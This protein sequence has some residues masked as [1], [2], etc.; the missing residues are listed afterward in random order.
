MLPS[1]LDAVRRARS[2]FILATTSFLSVC[3]TARPLLPTHELHRAPYYHE[4][5]SATPLPSGVVGHLPVRLDGR[6][7]GVLVSASVVQPLVDAMNAFLDSAGWSRPLASSPEP[8]LEGPDVYVGSARDTADMPGRI[9]SALARRLTMVVGAAGPSRRWRDSLRV[10]A[11]REGVTH[12]LAIAIGTSRYYAR[13]FL[14]LLPRNL[15]LG[16]GYTMPMSRLGEGDSPVNVLHVTG[17]LLTVD[18]RVLRVGAEGIVARVPGRVLSLLDVSPPLT[19]PYVRAVLTD[20]RRQ[21]LP[22]HPLAWAVAL[23]NLVGQLLGDED[24]IV[25]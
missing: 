21:D 22:G 14:P 1:S 24:L 19:A 16:T 9:D 7:H 17:A 3:A 2:A 5:G 18:G 10:L 6:L 25:R 8:E 12:V 11:A 13:Q 23:R 4:Y 20:E 15:E